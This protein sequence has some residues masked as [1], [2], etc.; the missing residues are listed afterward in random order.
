[1]K[2]H[3]QPEKEGFGRHPSAK[4]FCLRVGCSLRLRAIPEGDFGFAQSP[5]GTSLHP[6]YRPLTPRYPSRIKTI[7]F[8]LSLLS[9][10]RNCFA[11]NIRFALTAILP[12]LF[13]SASA[14]TYS[15]TKVDAP[16]YEFL[17]L[18]ES[19]SAIAHDDILNERI[20]DLVKASERDTVVRRKWTTHQ[21]GLFNWFVKGIGYW[22]QAIDG[23]RYKFVGTTKDLLN[24]QPN[25]DDFLTEHDINFN[26][27]PHLPHYQE[28]MMRGYYTQLSTK[29]ARD[30]N[31]S[32]PP[33]T[34][35]TDSTLQQYRLHCELTPPKRL[36][37]SL[38]VLFYPCL[39]GP[40]LDK[41]PNFC[42]PHPTMGM[43]GM[44]V[45]DC[46]HSCHPEI[47]P[48]EWLWWLNLGL[49]EERIG[50]N[51]KIWVA[52]LMRESSNRFLSW[53]RRPRVGTI[54][55]PFL[56]KRSEEALIR[57][58][59]L[60]VSKLKPKGV[61]KMHSLPEKMESFNASSFQAEISLPDGAGFPIHIENSRTWN[62]GGLNW[63]LSDLGTDA[64]G[65]WVWGRFNIL[66]SVR[67]CW[68]G[69]IKIGARP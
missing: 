54:S 39:P 57:I 28:M 10:S 25:E 40:N 37:D 20:V 23:K 55:I 41:H 60:V 48:Y 11:M 2:S 9:I 45:M 6:Q 42:D 27:L 3:Q 43:Y 14:Q 53:S 5:S 34:W 17:L 26:L 61:N 29:K 38:N 24:L 68:T 63:W 12:F 49:G 65:E 56:F 33:Y 35:P 36:R 30:K 66:A 59:H 46:N 67:D 44:F 13:L 51:E 8:I 31:I 64:K 18:R 21:S 52:G 32:K 16:P 7:A 50:Q 22:W 58:E 47:H 15:A 69:R 4:Y 19:N 1:M 62:S